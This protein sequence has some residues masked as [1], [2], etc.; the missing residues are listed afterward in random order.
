MLYKTSI[1][2][3]ITV[4]LKRAKT[5]LVGKYDNTQKS[6]GK[7]KNKKVLEKSLKKTP[8]Y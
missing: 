3:Q 4:E 8:K 6:V 2:Q 5:T 1:Y 7:N